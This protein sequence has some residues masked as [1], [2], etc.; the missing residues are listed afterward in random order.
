MFFEASEGRFSKI[1]FLS[2]KDNLFG[3]DI[4]RVTTG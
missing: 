2:G 1:N 3:G 4:E